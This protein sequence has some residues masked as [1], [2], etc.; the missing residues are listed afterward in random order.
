[1]KQE[2]CSKVRRH[3]G[4]TY[5]EFAVLCGLYSC[6]GEKKFARVSQP[7]IRGCALGYRT[8]A[9]MDAE[10]ARRADGAQPLSERQLRDTIARLHRNHFFARCTY[11]RRVTYY[12]IRLPEDEL[13]KKIVEKHSYAWGYRASQAAKDRAMTA[14]RSEPRRTE[15]A[16]LREGWVKAPRSLREKSTTA[17]AKVGRAMPEP[18]ENPRLIHG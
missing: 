12:S 2:W 3:K 7:R 8:A 14:D 17:P 4:L 18:T 1:M 16:T 5:R 15:K 9:I 10:F 13:R 11:A 6:I